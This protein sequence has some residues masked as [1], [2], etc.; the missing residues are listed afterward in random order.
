[1]NT[2]SPPSGSRKCRPSTDAT[3]AKQSMLVT[4]VL[5]LTNL[6]AHNAVSKTQLTMCACEIKTGCNEYRFGRNGFVLHEY[7]MNVV[8]VDDK[9]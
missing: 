7:Y 2:A 5:I 4:K 6:N 8:Y 3:I 1:M 9:G